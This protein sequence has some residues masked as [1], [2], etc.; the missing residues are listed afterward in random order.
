MCLLVDDILN[1]YNIG[2]IKHLNIIKHLLKI[3][4][5]ILVKYIFTRSF[6]NFINNK[7]E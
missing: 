6:M 1:V 3:S 5:P 2:Y 4:K 7:N